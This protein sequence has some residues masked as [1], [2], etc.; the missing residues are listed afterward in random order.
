[1]NLQEKV[2]QSRALFFDLFHTLFSFKTD[3]IEGGGTSE[4]LGI[5]EAVWDEL[6]FNKSDDRMKGINT[7]KYSIIRE[8]AH[9]YD[10]GISEEIIRNAADMREKRFRTG[11]INAD[12]SRAAVLAELKRM[13]KK[14]GLIS[15]ADAVEISGWPESPFA[16]YFDS[17]VFSYQI[18]FIKPEPEIYEY[19]LDSLG[20]T[21]EESIFVGDGG[22]DEFRGAKR[23]G[24]TTVMTTEIAGKRWPEKIAERSTYADYVIEGLGKLISK[25]L[26]VISY[27]L[28]VNR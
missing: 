21:A 19:A 13:N 28:S 23:V 25:K 14:I 4:L 17:V 9:A 22:S 20:V 24:F 8:L 12:R 15:N 6:V 5:P 27:Q 11:L 2:K 18:G 10:P 26:T 7:D 1:M 3:A 16:P